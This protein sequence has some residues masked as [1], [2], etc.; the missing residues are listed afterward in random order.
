MLIGEVSG[1]DTRI[2]DLDSDHEKK[3]SWNSR[4]VQ[5]LDEKENNSKGF[6]NIILDSFD[7]PSSCKIK[8]GSK[9]GGSASAEKEIDGTAE[10]TAEVHVTTQSDDGNTCIKAS[11]EASVDNQGNYGGKVEVRIEHEF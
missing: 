5:L 8:A 4:Q 6:V 1:F 10:V 3:I 11:G 7:K 2:D 9:I